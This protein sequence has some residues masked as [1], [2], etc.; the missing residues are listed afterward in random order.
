MKEMKR[1]SIVWG[2]IM[3]AIFVLLTFFGLKWKERYQGYFDLETKLKEETKKY[4]ESSYSYPDRGREIT[5]TLSE[6]VHN[7]ILKELSYNYD[8]CDGYVI[9]SNDDVIEYKP[10]IKCNNYT[11]RGYD[12][13]K[14]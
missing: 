5:I 4:F 9:V 2:V 14:S 10:Y 3:V 8:L 11:T 12:K 6:L 1:M 13:Q 7:G